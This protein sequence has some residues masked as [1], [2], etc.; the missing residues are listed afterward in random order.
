MPCLFGLIK[1]ESLVTLLI[2][3]HVSAFQLPH[4]RVYYF[5]IKLKMNGGV[6]EF[7]QRR[8]SSSSRRAFKYR[9]KDIQPMLIWVWLTMSDATRAGNDGWIF[10][11]L[12]LMMDCCTRAWL[13]RI[14]LGNTR[15]DWVRRWAVIKRR[16]S[17]RLPISFS[18]FFFAINGPG[19]SNRSR[20]SCGFFWEV[21]GVGWG[22]HE[23][24]GEEKVT[25]VKH[26]FSHDGGGKQWGTADLM[27][28]KVHFLLRAQTSPLITNVSSRRLA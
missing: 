5:T 14:S 27:A 21:G 22:A 7:D 12:A 23:R 26:P 13:R 4:S 3:F 10:P 25:L 18:F 19:I 17:F 20:K 8:S 9:S 15:R 2:I 24:E 16:N 28:T 1:Q 6:K 11:P